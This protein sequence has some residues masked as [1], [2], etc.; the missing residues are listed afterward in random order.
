[1]ARDRPLIPR[2]RLTAVPRTPRPPRQQAQPQPSQDPTPKK[3][4]LEEGEVAADSELVLAEDDEGILV[5][6]F[7]GEDSP[8][9]GEEIIEPVESDTLVSKHPAIKKS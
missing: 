9:D 1:M 3:R 6:S 8:G 5:E 4:K 2:R 7:G